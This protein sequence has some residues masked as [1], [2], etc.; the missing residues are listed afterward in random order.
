VA[1]IAAL[2]CLAHFLYMLP[3]SAPLRGPASTI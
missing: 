3:S 2:L 1:M